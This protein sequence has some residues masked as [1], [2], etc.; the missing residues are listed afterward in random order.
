MGAAVSD[1]A[2]SSE[3][4]AVADA[5]EAGGPLPA[6]AWE[7]QAPRRAPASTATVMIPVRRVYPTTHLRRHECSS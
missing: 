2:A 5:D 7:A 4:P 1:D 6:L 3:A